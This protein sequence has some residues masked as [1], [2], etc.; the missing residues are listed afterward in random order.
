M[1]LG[2]VED[3]NNIR[4]VQRATFEFLGKWTIVER[5]LLLNG[6]DDC[7]TLRI[8]EFLDSVHRR[9]F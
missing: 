9:I 2:Y 1:D 5:Y 7:V 3:I 8:T 4:R 6:S